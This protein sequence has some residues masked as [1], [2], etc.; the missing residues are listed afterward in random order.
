MKSTMSSAAVLA[1]GTSPFAAMAQE[2]QASTS[3]AADALWKRA[4]SA[5]A[6]DLVESALKAA[7]AQVSSQRAINAAQRSAILLGDG[8][9]KEYHKQAETQYA[10]RTAALQKTKQAL[11]AFVKSNGD[12]GKRNFTE[13]AAKGGMNEFVE[14][15]RKSTTA[16]L[17]HSD[18]SPDEARSA[19]KALDDRLGK[20][21]EMK[22]FEDV[23]SYL[24]KHLDE[25]IE[26]KMSEAD[27]NG[28]CV[29]LLLLTSL[30]VVLILIAVLI[31]V[32]TLGLGCQGIL[33]QLI[34][35]ACP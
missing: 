8:S 23:T 32:F 20:L 15:A 6:R 4:D 21:Q 9:E 13:F 18:I 11:A 7:K 1:L 33:D 16:A 5:K 22:S 17:L 29:L 27:P 31:C 25:L 30:Y 3:S 28:L 10:A 26:H 34:A 12:A 24:D 2:K 19:K 14:H 35:Q